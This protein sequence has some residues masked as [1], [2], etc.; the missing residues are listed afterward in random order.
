MFQKA[1]SIFATVLIFSSVAISQEIII[2]ENEPGFCN[3]DGSVQTSVSGYTGDGYADADRGVG[4]SMSWSV[5]AP[6]DASYKIWWKYANGG[7]SGDRPAK[8]I[9]NSRI[10]M[11][12]LNFA[13]TG[14]WT[15]WSNSDT[16][17]VYFIE[18]SNQ[19]RLEGYSGD[20]L[21]NY[22]YF[23]AIG[24]GLEPGECKPFYT[25]SVNVNDA[26]AGTASVD[27]V[28]DYYEEGNTITLIAT[29]NSGYFFQSW[30]GDITSDEQVHVFQLRDNVDITARFLPDGAEMD[31]DL[32]G[33]A[34]VQDD[35]GTP[36]LVTGGSL[37]E[38]VAADNLEELKSYLDGDKHLT[39]TLDHLIE[40]DDELKIG[41]NKTLLGI[42]DDAHL[43]GIEL[44][45]NGARNV[46]IKNLKVSHVTPAD[47]IVITGKSQNI[48]IDHCDIFS[49]RDHGTEYYD[50]LLDIK[51]ESSFITISWTKFHDHFK[52]SLISSGDDSVQD[53]VIRVT[54]H[55]NYFYN[56][57]SRLPSIRFGKAHVFNNYYKDCGTAINSRMGACVRVERNYFDNVGTAVM[58]RYSPEVGSV[59]LIDNHF[60]S[61]NYSTSPECVLNIPY[62][63]ESHLDETEQIP[64]II[65]NELV[66]SVED[67]T[68]A[69]LEFRLSQNYPNPFNPVTTI[70]YSIPVSVISNEQSEVRNLLDFSSINTQGR[71]SSGS[72]NDKIPVGLKVYDILGREVTTLVDES[73]SPGI[74]E[75]TLDG[76]HLPTGIYIYQ[77]RSGNF[78]QSKKLMLLK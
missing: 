65:T 64:E 48:W 41:S 11:D 77:L 49:D 10:F 76:S 69:P 66:T 34:T 25:V 33:Y 38:T 3:L 16:V 29:P 40:A 67:K 24:N 73:Q 4:V 63:Y 58:M 22:D 30:T 21:G 54:Y 46:I 60:G 75:V 19:I 71:Q 37:G 2:Q 78:V 42:G 26:D 8:L 68:R 35:K 45:I 70:A 39:V 74:Y 18:G 6:A 59:Q 15:N 44:E 50:G 20:G 72:R 31:T 52:T 14:E 36:Y 7:G 17:E 53:T 13:H 23:A 12:T 9:I 56:C 5:Y 57:E 43:K 1:I 28:K 51:N 32:I 47:A 55:H 62:E 61:S 27:P